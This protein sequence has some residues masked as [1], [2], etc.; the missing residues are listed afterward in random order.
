MKYSLYA[1]LFSLAL[2]FQTKIGFAQSR[3]TY[4]LR[5]D[6]IANGFFDSDPEEEYSFTKINLVIPGPSFAVGGKY[7][8]YLNNKRNLKI[9]IS[10]MLEFKSF[11][12]FAS[13]QYD[14]EA[15]RRSKKRFQSINLAA[16]FTI[17]FVNKKWSYSLGFAPAVSLRTK[18]KYSSCEFNNDEKC[19]YREIY[20]IAQYLGNESQAGFF[21]SE[22]IYSMKRIDFQCLIGIQKR[23]KC[24]LFVCRCNSSVTVTS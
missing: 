6:I 13:F 18:L 11:T 7:G 8:Y 22:R 10:H 20:S 2:L 17:D 1:S 23:L 4:Q 24:K 15:I 12:R 16:P 14:S 19:N 21:S 5:S 3:F 9:S